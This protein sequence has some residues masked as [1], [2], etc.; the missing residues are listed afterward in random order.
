MYFGIEPQWVRI[1]MHGVYRVPTTTEHGRGRKGK[2]EK[3]EKKM[4]TKTEGYNNFTSRREFKVFFLFLV[5][6]S[7]VSLSTVWRIR[8]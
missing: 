8:Y 6:V 2:K 5:G 1:S 4:K 7:D 3:R